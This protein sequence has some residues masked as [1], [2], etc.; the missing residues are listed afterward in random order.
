MVHIS[1]IYY[2]SAAVSVQFA[3]SDLHTLKDERRFVSQGGLLRTT[4]TFMLLG[5][6]FFDTVEGKPCP[7][8]SLPRWLDWGTEEARKHKA[9][10]SLLE[11]PF[12]TALVLISAIL[13]FLINPLLCH[14]L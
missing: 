13:I 10:Q 14:L 8:T 3:L 11:S 7:E 4:K 2:P 12:R 5:M 1:E 6:I 9:R